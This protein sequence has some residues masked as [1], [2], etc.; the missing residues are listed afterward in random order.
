[1][2][3]QEYWNNLW[4]KL[5]N[6]KLVA[7]LAFSLFL[8]SCTSGAVPPIA[9]REPPPSQRI[10]EHE[11][12][13]GET[14]YIIAWR[15]ETDYRDMARI[16]G[17]REPYDLR[18]GQQL[19]IYDDGSPTPSSRTA[20][21]VD[22]SAEV[23][24]VPVDPKPE[25]QTSS[26]STNSNPAPVQTPLSTEAG[27]WQWPV[28]GR[29]TSAFGSSSLTRGIEI[30]PGS[31]TNVEAAAEGQVVYAGAG[32]RGVGNLIIVKHSDLFLSAYA[33]NSSLLAKE[34]DTVQAGQRIARVGNDSNGRPRVYFE[35]R[36]DG[37]PVDPIRYLPKR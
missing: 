7:C 35:I 30:D 34:G 6:T 25:I 3:M 36:R 15:Y 31:V 14:L 9:S 10:N 2:R 8:L 5:L 13:L 21:V 20:P 12:Q 4:S 23:R 19:K 32:I 11:V 26:S 22:R 33:Y 37:Q 28:A 18:L 29:V 27:R 24:T 17:L 1:M 16:N